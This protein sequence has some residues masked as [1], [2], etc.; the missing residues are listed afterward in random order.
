MIFSVPVGM[1]PPIPASCSDARPVNSGFE[2]LESTGD[3]LPNGSAPA[4]DP[5]ATMI[6]TL[7]LL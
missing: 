2:I 6:L 5:V 7:F 3:G 1:S 4:L